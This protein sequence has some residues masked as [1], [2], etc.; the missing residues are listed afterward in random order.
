MSTPA[1][2]KA[3]RQNSRK[4]S[5]PKT[6]KGKAIS[7]ANAW[8]HGLLSRNVVGPKEDPADF[9]A[10]QAQL[11]AEWNPVGQLEEEVLGRIAA[12]LWRLRRMERVEAGLF[13]YHYHDVLAKRAG[14]RAALFKKDAADDIIASR[15]PVIDAAECIAAKNKQR[16]HE[17]KQQ[18]DTA[19]LGAAFLEDA[20]KVDAFSKLVRYEA[21]IERSLHRNLHELQR[22]QANRTGQPVPPPVVVDV[23]ISTG[24]GH[25][26]E[27][28]ETVADSVAEDTAQSD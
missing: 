24:N 12:Q 19:T 3:N 28:L 23:D 6:T 21:T 13:S 8:K 25:L 10:L 5:G 15:S 22:L 20:S 9:E 11:R 16:A 18:S 1:Q 14:K 27:A 7:S 17:T 26:G 2:D 4:S